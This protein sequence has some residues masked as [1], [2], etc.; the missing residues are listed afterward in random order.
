MLHLRIRRVAADL[1][2]AIDGRHLSPLLDSV[3]RD[4]LRELLRVGEHLGPGVQAHVEIPIVAGEV[5]F[6]AGPGRDV[7]GELGRELLLSGLEREVG[8]GLQQEI[9]LVHDGSS[10]SR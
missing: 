6:L 10:E 4:L 9:R 2:A 8:A 3:S 7:L 1:D 5:Q